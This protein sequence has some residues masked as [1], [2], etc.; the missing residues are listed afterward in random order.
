MNS[1]LGVFSLERSDSSQANSN[2]SA[3]CSITPGK[4]VQDVYF[5]NDKS[6]FSN[7]SSVAKTPE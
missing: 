6:I 1:T 2:L 5:F 3:V 4:V 7:H